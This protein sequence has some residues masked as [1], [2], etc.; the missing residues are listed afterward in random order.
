MYLKGEFLFDLIAAIPISLLFSPVDMPIYIF[1]LFNALKLLKGF[2]TY[3]L[4]RIYREYSHINQLIFRTA[5]SLILLLIVNNAIGSI[6]YLIAKSQYQSGAATS[7]LDMVKYKI[8]CFEQKSL[9]S[10]TPSSDKIG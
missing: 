9:L 6:M 7:G 3:K 1:G 5:N 4:Y 8:M 2:R 10:V